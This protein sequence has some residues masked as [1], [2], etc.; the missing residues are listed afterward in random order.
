MNESVHLIW[1]GGEVSVP[2]RMGVSRDDQLLGTP[3]ERVVEL[4]GRICYDS[5]GGGR[6][7]VEYFKHILSVG[8]TSV[9]AHV[10]V[11]VLIKD[12]PDQWAIELLNR[13]GVWVMAVPWTRGQG[14]GGIRVT[15]NLR[16]ILEWDKWGYGPISCIMAA[17]GHQVAPQIISDEPK[18][19]MYQWT[20]VA[21]ES[22]EEQFLTIWMRGSRGFSHEQVR[23]TFRCAVSQRST[24]RFI[25]ISSPWILHPLLQEP[26]D[27]DIVA[28][29]CESQH[30]YRRI[31]KSLVKRGHTR[32]EARGC[33]RGMLGNALGAE[34][35]FTASLAQWDRMI[36][37]R[38]S[39][40]ADAEIRG[41]YDSVVE[42]RSN[43]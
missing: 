41:I 6:S 39:V 13:P 4:A 7:S 8:H 35:I 3:A 29:I 15:A 1:S 38:H 40:H 10:N 28:Q 27:E 30:L 17:A 23:H 37:Q 21:P 34:L 11:T 24:R 2:P 5:L 19:S 20:I 26:I 31:V 18:G 32:K 33:A 16:A 22:L 9:L 42:I 14:I 12:P 43:L 25:A 36:E